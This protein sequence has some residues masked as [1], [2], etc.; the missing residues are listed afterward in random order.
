M[1]RNS[2]YMRPS[3]GVEPYV[4]NPCRVIDEIGDI[5]KRKFEFVLIDEISAKEFSKNNFGWPRNTVSQLSTIQNESQVNA[6]LRYMQNHP[7]QYNLKDGFSVKDAFDSIRPRSCQMPTEFEEFAMHLANGDM[8]KLNAA[9]E[10]ALSK[11]S[12]DK[13]V[14]EVKDVTDDK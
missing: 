12:A 11:K 7:A 4:V 6:V 5:E 3:D 13:K 1:V 8:N 10:K 14:N 9:Y 2:N